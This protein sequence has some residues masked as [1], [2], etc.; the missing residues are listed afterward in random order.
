MPCGQHNSQAAARPF[1]TAPCL[2]D[3]LPL[4]FG[5]GH[6]A[7][8]F[9]S[10]HEGFGMPVLEAFA[11]GLPCVITDCKGPSMFAV[12]GHNCWVAAPGDVQGLA[13]GLCSALSDRQT[14]ARLGAAAR[15]AAEQL[16]MDRMGVAMESLLYACCICREG[17][18]QARAQAGQAIL[19][20]CRL[21]AAG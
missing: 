17:L 18:M 10:T 15:A 21:V 11:C 4:V 13:D 14:A 8:L 6:A 20:A 19:A 16:T 3:Q 7:M 12:H 1:F 2:Q 9:T 5:Q